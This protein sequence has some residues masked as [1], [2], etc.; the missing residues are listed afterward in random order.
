MRKY[1]LGLSVSV[2]LVT[3]TAAQANSYDEATFRLHQGMNAFEVSQAIGRPTRITM[4]TCGGGQF[5]EIPRWQCQLWEY[6]TN[7]KGAYGGILKDHLLLR[8]QA[9]RSN[10]WVLNSWSV[11]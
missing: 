3:A 5:G 10:D 1:L 11:Y 9:G 4:H 7:Q 8:F 6:E 2:T